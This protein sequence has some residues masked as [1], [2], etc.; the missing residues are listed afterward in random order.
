MVVMANDP[1]TAIIINTSGVRERQRSTIA[2]VMADAMMVI[3][4]TPPRL[5][6]QVTSRSV[7]ADRKPRAPSRT[8]RSIPARPSPSPTDS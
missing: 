8:G 7:V 3:P 4:T 5:V 2:R 1:A 6:N